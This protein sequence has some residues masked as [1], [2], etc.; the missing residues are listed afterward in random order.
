MKL[1]ISF[2]AVISATAMISSASHA[3]NVTTN[4]QSSEFSFESDGETLNGTLHKPEGEGPFPAV[5]AMHGSGP[6][7]RDSPIYLHLARALTEAGTAVLLF[8]PPRYRHPA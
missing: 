1:S 7:E 2:S 4:A 3:D 8:R 5:V 6:G